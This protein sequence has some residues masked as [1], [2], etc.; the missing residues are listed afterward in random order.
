MSEQDK[1]TPALY[2]GR[3]QS[4]V[5]H[6][7]LKDYLLRLALIVGRHS[8]SITYIDGFSGPWNARGD[9]LEDASFSIAL[10]M[11]RQA[12]D[13]LLTQKQTVKLRCYFIEEDAAA[14]AQL[15][16]FAKGITDAEV[17][18]RNCEFESAIPDIVK[19]VRD[20]GRTFPFVF[21]DPTGWTGF[22]MKTIQPLLQLRPGEVLVNFMTRH[23]KR[24]IDAPEKMRHEEFEQLFGSDEYKQ[25]PQGLNPQDREDAMV[26]LY[27]RGLRQAG[28]FTYACAAMVL[29]PEIEATHFHLIYATRHPK[30]VEVFKEA[31]KRAMALQEAARA[32]AQQRQ[33]IQRTGQGEMFGAKELAKVNHYAM[34][35][36]RYTSSAKTLISERI[37]QHGEID[38]DL[39]WRIA[40]S[41]PLVWESDLKD[42]VKGW[43]NDGRLRIAGLKT[44]ERVPHY[45]KGH[46]LVRVPPQKST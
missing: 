28:G 17:V 40:L 38:Y 45:D 22:A 30:G 32:E 24:F 7:I 37:E 25:I 21:I 31:E 26:Q 42:W 15:D 8:D 4:W 9:K 23:I 43:E 34:L 39:A 29:H 13:Q 12:R 10:R 44:R 3:E 35:R 5:K 1:K 20:S 6:E 19:F 14:F 2:E 16:E 33:R 36:E 27:M 18:A 46:R 11:L 41:R